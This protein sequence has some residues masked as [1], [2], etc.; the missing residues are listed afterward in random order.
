MIYI[1]IAEKNIFHLVLG[2]K[3]AGALHVG[4]GRRSIQRRR[5]KIVEPSVFDV[6]WALVKSESHHI[7]CAEIR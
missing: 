7:S 6:N 1:I 3:M 5:L 4:N 2:I